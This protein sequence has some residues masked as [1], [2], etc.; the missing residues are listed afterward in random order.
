MI[1]TSTA[2]DI[3]VPSQESSLDLNI[4]QTVCSV[5][6]SNEFTTM[7]RPD[8]MNKSSC[9]VK[10]KSLGRGYECTKGDEGNLSVDGNPGLN[11]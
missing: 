9:R 2:P 8:W 3:Y 4:T 5:I 6:L 10:A 11:A 1:G 7:P